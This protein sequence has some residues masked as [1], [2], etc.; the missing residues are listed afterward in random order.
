MMHPNE[1]MQGDFFIE[2]VVLQDDS[3]DLIFGD[4]IWQN[5]QD[6]AKVVEIAARILKPGGSLILESCSY[7]RFQHET[8]M[9]ATRQDAMTPRSLLIEKWKR[10]HLGTWRDLVTVGFR[11]YIFMG[12]KIGKKIARH[13]HWIPDIAQGGGQNMKQYFWQDSAAYPDTIIPKLVEKGGVVVDPFSGSGLIT[14]VCIKNGLICYAW[15]KEPDIFKLANENLK[16][17]FEEFWGNSGAF[18]RNTEREKKLLE[19]TCIRLA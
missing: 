16:L 6:Y 4:P 17:R 15:E 19:D 9:Y 5:I 7:Y 18:G 13:G 14:A 11:P 12:K 8:A 2:S 3:V 1:V 10:Q